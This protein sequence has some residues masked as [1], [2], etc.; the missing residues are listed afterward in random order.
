MRKLSISII[1]LALL[2]GGVYLVVYPDLPLESLKE[3]YAPP[4]SRFLDV[5]GTAVHYRIET[6]GETTGKPVL[7]LIHGTGASLHTWEAWVERLRDDYVLVRFDLPGHGL[8]GPAADPEFAY[9]YPEYAEFTHAFVRAAGLDRVTVAGN[10]LGGGIAWVFALEHPLSVSHLILIDA[11]GYPREKSPPIFRLARTPVVGEIMRYVS[12]RFM[13]RRNLE[14]VYGNDALI[15]DALIDRYHDLLRREGNRG[16]LLKRIRNDRPPPFERIGEI[17]HPTLIL[18]GGQDVWIPPEFGER[19]DEDLPNSKLI[20]YDDA[21]HI[22]MEEIPG[23]TAEDVRA[24][25]RDR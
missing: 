1:L 7:L 3:K 16:A 17:R 22:P 5:Q 9:T 20:F 8:T 25:L 15:T 2:S 4:P 23:R 12:P 13:I 24:F 6:N 11:A 19:F 10:S 14:Q 18:W 21:G